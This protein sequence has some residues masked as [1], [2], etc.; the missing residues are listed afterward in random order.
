MS[1][2]FLRFYVDLIPDHGGEKEEGERDWMDID[3]THIFTYINLKLYTLLVNFYLL[4]I[5]QKS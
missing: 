5:F 1:V 3:N 4:D 2:L